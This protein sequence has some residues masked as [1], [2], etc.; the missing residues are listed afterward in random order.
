VPYKPR[1]SPHI[2]TVHARY[3]DDDECEFIAAMAEYRKLNGKPFPTWSE[4]LG[5]LKG[6]GYT[7]PDLAHAGFG[8]AL[9]LTQEG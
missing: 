7:K 8:P 4:A 3:Y 6:L 9:C 5:V 1:L 2:A